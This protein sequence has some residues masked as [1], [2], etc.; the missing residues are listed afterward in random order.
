[1]TGLPNINPMKMLV[2]GHNGFVGSHFCSAYGGIP[3]VDHEGLVDLRDAARV[4][5]A[6]D[7]IAPEAVLHLA[8]QSFVSQSFSDPMETFSINF[9]GTLNL[10]QALDFREFSSTLARPTCMEG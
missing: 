9:L 10:L 4:H 3:L 1:M 5:S 7:A 8:A 2:T 6:I